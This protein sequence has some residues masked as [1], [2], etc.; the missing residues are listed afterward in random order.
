MNNSQTIEINWKYNILILHELN[1]IYSVKEFQLNHLLF[2]TIFYPLLNKN[3]SLAKFK[4]NFSILSL[5]KIKCGNNQKR[6]IES[7]SLFYYRQK[8]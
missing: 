4:S 7:S 3:F 5:E 6:M 2:K 8:I 1:M